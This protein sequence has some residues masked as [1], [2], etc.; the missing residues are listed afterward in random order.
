MYCSVFTEMQLEK[1]FS[2]RRLDKGRTTDENISAIAA[3]K[4]KITQGILNLM[5]KASVD[6][7]IHT[8][9]TKEKKSG[10]TIKCF[11]FPID[12]K[13][14][15]LSYNPN[16][17]DD[18]LDKDFD[19]RVKKITWKGKKLKHGKKIYALNPENNK[20]YDLDSYLASRLVLVG[21]LEEHPETKKLIL[22]KL[23]K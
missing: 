9:S 17:D 2:I 12:S 11:S 8:Q 3:R 16:I 7:A 18:E 22:K 1:E 15:D 23:K 19:M 4:A 20:V 21:K 6:C 5:K 13:P 14:F 10:K